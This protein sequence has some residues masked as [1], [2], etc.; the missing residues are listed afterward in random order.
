MRSQKATGRARSLRRSATRPERLLWGQLCNRKLDGLKFRRQHPIGPY[1]A[2]FACVE[3]ML[4]IELDGWSHEA[5]VE[6]DT[7]RQSEIEAAGFRV[8]RFYNDDVLTY[9]E[10][11]VEAI[12]IALATY[13]ASPPR[14]GGEDG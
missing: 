5:T 4:V 1:I 9:P 7:K 13:A 11:V 6:R 12:R 14:S 8:I 10:G 3:R 2:D